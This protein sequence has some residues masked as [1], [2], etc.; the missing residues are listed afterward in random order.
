MKISMKK[1]KKVFMLGALSAALAGCGFFDTDNTPP[2]TPLKNFSSEKNA[3]TL[4]STRVGWGVGTDYLKLGPYVSEKAVFAANR[5]GTII[6][7]DKMTGNKLWITYTN[8][9][10]SAGPTAQEGLV[11]IGSR[12]GDV[13]ALNQQD[14]KIAWQVKVSTEVLAAPAIS[15][16]TVI[17]KA[18]DGK[19]VALSL[20]DGHTLWNYKEA[21]PALILRAAS[22]PQISHNNVVIGFANGSLA[23]LSLQDGGLLWKENLAYP[24]GI[25]AIQR[26]IDIDANPVI[27]NNR[28]YAA[29][30]QGKVAA[31]DLSSG[32]SFW[33]Q[34][35]S[36]YS[37]IAVDETQ[38][39]VSNAKSDLTAFS[40]ESG[41]SA[42][43]QAKLE[44]RNI[45]G[46]AM[47]D[48][49]LVVGDEQGYLHWINKQDG[50]FIARIKVGGEGILSTPIVNNNVVYV[51]TR[52]GHLAAYTLS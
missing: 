9:R 19:V 11:I 48:N 46:P 30:Y 22:T 8:V 42:W 50:R 31:I 6:A 27:F 7:T 12:E 47:M 15:D 45:T 17:I 36:S 26:M 40:A 51:L 39:Y 43:R 25:F 24:E 4:W 34:D 38:V 28:L 3:H 13:I 18:I 10:I 5:D 32:K 44:D 33:T 16:G 1:T 29:G 35:V 14:G 23:K 41:A 21:E 37:G 2:P 52:D 20:K 49:Y